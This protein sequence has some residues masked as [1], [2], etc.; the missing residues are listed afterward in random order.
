[1]TTPRG[2]YGGGYGGYYPSSSSF[3]DTPIYDSLVAER[4]TPQ[5]APIRVPAAYSPY[6]TG[7]YN[8][9]GGGSN[10]PA[11]PAA[12][13]A[14]PPGPSAPSQYPQPVPPPMPGPAQNGYPTPGY[15]Q[16]PTTYIPQQ[17]PAPRPAYNGYGNGNGSGNG[18]GNSYGNGYG[19]SNGAGYPAQAPQPSPGGY[20]AARPVPPRPMQPRQMPGGHPEEQYPRRNL[21]L[22]VPPQQQNG[23]YYQG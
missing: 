2:S 14:L 10:L 21:G 15:Q 23:G 3:P 16:Q 17:A 20:E 12:L 4:G 22:G 9:Y 13:P 11:L 19:N 5:I 1:M 6:E 8:S 7:G 18:S